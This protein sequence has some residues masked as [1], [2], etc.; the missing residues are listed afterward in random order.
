MSRSRLL[1]LAVQSEIWVQALKHRCEEDSG[2]LRRF[3]GFRS[4]KVT[5]CCHLAPCNIPT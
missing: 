3:L 2:S 4:I 5:S 1:G